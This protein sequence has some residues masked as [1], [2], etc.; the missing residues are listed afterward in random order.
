MF[1]KEVRVVAHRREALGEHRELALHG[2]LQRALG[3]RQG[4]QSG[5]APDQALLVQRGED[6][7][8]TG[9]Q[10][11]GDHLLDQ[12]VGGGQVSA[13]VADVFLEQGS[14]LFGLVVLA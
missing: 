12:G 9:D 5:R 10:V 14:G 11:D 8:I 3:G 6:A 13:P 4:R 7:D 1:L 2:A